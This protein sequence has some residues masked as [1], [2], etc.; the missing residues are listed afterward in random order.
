MTCSARIVLHH[1]TNDQLPLFFQEAARVARKKLILLDAVE[2]KTSIVSRMLWKYDRGS[3]PRTVETLSTAM[4]TSFAI[5]QTERFEV[6]HEYLI[7]IGR[8]LH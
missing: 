3:H 4:S 6:F 1:L 5:E 2:R 7:C 8:P